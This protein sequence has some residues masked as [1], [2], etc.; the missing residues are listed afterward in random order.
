MTAPGMM[1][2]PAI[3]VGVPRCLQCTAT[4]QAKLAH[5]EYTNEVRRNSSQGFYPKGQSSNARVTGQNEIL[6]NENLLK[7]SK[8]LYE[9]L[10]KT[11]GNN[12]GE[13]VD[14]ITAHAPFVR[15]PALYDIK[16]DDQ[17]TLEK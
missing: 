3:E 5:P 12:S 1:R 2:G 8:S 13:L 4:I 10:Q 17:V 14:G 9:D 11:W 7:I 16:A 6:G 15:I